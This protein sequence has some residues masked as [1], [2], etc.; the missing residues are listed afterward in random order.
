MEAYRGRRPAALRGYGVAGV[1]EGMRHGALFGDLSA[2]REGLS[3]GWAFGLG[4]L[5]ELARNAL[6]LEYGIYREGSLARRPDGVAFELTNPPLRLGAF[7]QLRVFW[8]GFSLDPAKV[9]V[10]TDRHPEPRAVATLSRSEPLELGVGEG[11]RFEL[12]LDPPPSAGHHRVRLEWTSSAIPPLV[13]MEFVDE[14][15]DAGASG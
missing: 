14:L 6:E 1:G 15:S 13:W 7:S 12:A 2:L 5:E 11:S 8:D 9:R 4:S 10:A 3:I